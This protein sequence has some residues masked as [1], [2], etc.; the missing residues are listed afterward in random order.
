MVK[1]Q[2][3]FQVYSLS[4]VTFVFWSELN[5]ISSILVQCLFGLNKVEFWLSWAQSL[6]GLSLKF[7]FGMNRVKLSLIII[8]VD[9]QNV[10]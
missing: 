5:S 1:F 3:L 8:M 4:L 2:N 7:L 9:F 6:L 10:F